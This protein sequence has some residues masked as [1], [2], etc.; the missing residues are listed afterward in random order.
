MPD[1]IIRDK[2]RSSPTLQRLSDAAERA[3]WR[4]TTAADDYGRF[5]SDPDVLLARLFER[6]PIGWTPSK[7][8]HVIKEW[9]SQNDPLIHLYQ[10]AGDPRV[11]GHSL[12]WSD[13]Q[14]E[15]D[16]KPKYPEPPCLTKGQ[17][18]TSQQLAARCRDSLQ[19]AARARTL[20]SD[21]DAGSD[22]DLNHTAR[23]KDARVPR[24]I[25]FYHKTFLARFGSPPAINGGKCGAVAKR[26]LAGRTLEDVQ[27]LIREH[28]ERPPDLYERKR[29]YGL[30]H[31]LSAANTLLARKHDA[32]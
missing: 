16:S 14:R 30:E 32:G 23:A 28:L 26:L 15:R 22:S 4:L 24:V 6:K 20:G 17:K 8:A 7:M 29:L 3:W 27:W 13:H 2:A 9:A 1:R 18:G 12:T 31:V 10:V 11:Y 19:V 25:D 5:D 21:S